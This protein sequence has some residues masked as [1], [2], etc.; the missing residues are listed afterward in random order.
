[1]AVDWGSTFSYFSEIVV[2]S[3]K[4]EFKD[5]PVTKQCPECRNNIVT[6]LR[7]KTGL[8]TYAVCFVLAFTGFF[9]GCCLIPFCA[10]STKDVIHECSMC[11]CEL[12]E[13]K[14]LK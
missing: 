4:A 3:P 9:L 1:M 12:G 10:K 11:G 6:T 2:E 14:R 7:Y 8:F 13:Y 5:S